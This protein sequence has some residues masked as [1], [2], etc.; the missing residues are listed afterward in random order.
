MYN[1]DIDLFKS[2]YLKYKTKYFSLKSMIGRGIE[3]EDTKEKKG[4]ESFD[5]NIR[6]YIYNTDCR[7]VIKLMGSSK[8]VGK[9]INFDTLTTNIEVDNTIN[10][11]NNRICDFVY[12]EEDEDEIR[13][14]QCNTY[15]NKCRIKS[16]FD[17]YYNIECNNTI[18]DIPNVYTKEILNQILLR[19]VPN[20]LLEDIKDNIVVLLALGADITKIPDRAFMQSQLTNIRI[21]E[22]ITWI[23]KGSFMGNRLTEIIIPDSISIIDEASFKNNKLIKINI[24]DS[25][26]KIGTVAFENN[27]LTEINI[28]DSV[29]II[30][31]RAFAINIFTRIRIPTRFKTRIN[32]IFNIASGTK[33]EYY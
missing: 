3:T 25:V 21:P 16:L 1:L 22:C 6:D 8:S 31:D 20:N 28:P 2:K 19:T 14:Y 23:G 4:L 13:K 11:I 30:G 18:L 32:N 9:N 10:I 26:T 5:N 7:N 27:K 12:R 33:I 17:K 29:T 24:P 15:Y